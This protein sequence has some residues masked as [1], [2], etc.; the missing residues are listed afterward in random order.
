MMT[1]ERK[2][3]KEIADYLQSLQESGL[4]VYYE[5]REAGGFTYKKGLPDIW[6]AV[7]GRH[8]ELEIKKPGGKRKL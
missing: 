2:V 7:A 4:P 1:P 5:A 3:K 6:L 8:I